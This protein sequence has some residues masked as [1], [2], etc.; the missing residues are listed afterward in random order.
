MRGDLRH[1]LV[2]FNQA[3]EI[4]KT[5][6]N[7]YIM[8]Q[9]RVRRS[10]VYRT[11]GDYNLALID[12]EEALTLTEGKE[13]LKDIE[14]EAWRMKGMA[15]YYLGHIKEAL[16]YLLRSLAGYQLLNE[17]EKAAVLQM[18][19]GMVHIAS[20]NYLA[21]EQSFLKSLEYWQGTNNSVWLANILNNLGD[22]QRLM[23][24]FETAIATL[25]KAIQYARDSGYLR[26]EAYALASI[27]DL[28]NDLE[29]ADQ[30]QEA[31][32]KARIISNR[33]QDQYL[34]V[35]IDLAEAV[36]A[37]RRGNTFKA[38]KLL[39]NAKNLASISGSGYE[40]NLCRL[41]SGRIKII[42]QDYNKAI[43]ELQFA[44][45]YFQQEGHK[46]LNLRAKLYLAIAGHEKQPAAPTKKEL[47]EI[48]ATIA[49]PEYLNSM[50]ATIR[51]VKPC[52]EILKSEKDITPLVN[53]IFQEI[54]RF[55]QSLSVLRRHFRHAVSVVPF[56]PPKMYIQALG[57]MQVRVNDHVVT[58]ADWQ[59]QTARD[60]FFFLLAR[61]DGVTKETVGEVFWIESSPAELKM[62]FK[63]T[64]YRLRHAV[65]KEAIIFQDDIYQFNT[66]LDYEYDVESFYREIYHAEK[67]KDSHQRIN[68]YQAAIKFFQGPYLPDGD[69]T[70]ILI[71]RQKIHNAYV[72]AVMQ[73]TSLYLEDGEYQNALKCSQKILSDDPCLEDA[74]RLAMR[75]YAGMGNRGAV[76]RQ[77]EYCRQVL[78]EELD[79][80]PSQQTQSLYEMLMH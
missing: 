65:G 17:P 12:A 8:A 75:A 19:I 28:Y 25:E 77:Y 30:A 80:K 7:N 64:I 76:A 55:D 38:L 50:L 11:M 13:G 45:E 24:D 22:L 49:A 57:K 32:N 78:S 43:P 41:E 15:Y 37:N 18:E 3:M 73:L 14:A 51:E 10:T 4:L 29:A 46:M 62:R 33:I 56:A 48:I 23:R 20:G 52:L 68:A 16:G 54:D 40:Q 36:L 2:L 67:A 6:P 47:K 42:N 1:G 71:E 31:Y 69:D 9:L 39:E 21:A 74:H 34:L 27:G 53:Y 70:W 63:N 35:Y 72:N 61:R 26:L 60:L 59:T 5:N 44:E 58:N 66:S 79:V